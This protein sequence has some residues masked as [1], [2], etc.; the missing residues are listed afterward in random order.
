[1]ETNAVRT[2]LGA[3]G[4]AL[5]TDLASRALVARNLVPHRSL[6][7]AVAA[8]VPG[9]GLL[10]GPIGRLGLE[11]CAWAGWTEAPPQLLALPEGSLPDR[12][13]AMGC[14]LTGPLAGE[15]ASSLTSWLGSTGVRHLACAPL[16]GAQ[17]AAVLILGGPEPMTPDPRI[18]ALGEL[19]LGCAALERELAGERHL[20]ELLLDAVGQGSLV[21]DGEG[22]VLARSPLAEQLLLSLGLDPCA[23]GVLAELLGRR[24]WRALRRA[25]AS[26][27][28]ERHVLSITV[29]G[30]ARPLVFTICPL[31]ASGG[32]ARIALLLREIGQH[33][34]RPR[35]VMRRERL[36]ALGQMAAGAAHEIRNPLTAIRGFLQLLAD[37]VGDPVQARYLQIVRHEIDRIEGITGQMLLLSRPSSSRPVPL[38]VEELLR[39]AADLVRG[40]A[41]A[42]GVQVQ[43][44]V[45][46]ELPQ[47]Y[48]DAG[49][50]EQVLL[51]L[52]SN[53]VEAMARPGLVEVEVRAAPRHMLEIRVRDQGPGIPRAS[54]PRIFDPFFTTKA[55]GTGLGL[56][57]S[58]SIVR[59]MGGHITVVSPP[60]EGATFTVRLPAGGTP[61]RRQR[62]RLRAAGPGRSA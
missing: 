21:C 42:V 23:D 50:L 14:P 51:N 37:Q 28:R 45:A 36:A 16:A 27:R 54:L 6:L 60:G 17:Q 49:G 4:T 61:A 57:V 13:R 53:A 30:Q 48:G 56:A 22:R 52:L 3:E 39:A 40:S 10:I 62:R 11:V 12:A 26:G 38:N 20:R 19:A 55:G 29:Q 8:M 7:A 32:Q 31:P 2:G 15:P 44:R 9:G 33:G 43:L 1:M 35:E 41:G 47:V 24:G 5:A 18:V 25:Q 59:S 46:P 58:E 34:S